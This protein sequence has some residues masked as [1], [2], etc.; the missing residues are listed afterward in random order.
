MRAILSALL[1]LGCGDPSQPGVKPG[2][3]TVSDTVND[4]PSGGGGGGGDTPVADE[5]G[6]PGT[7]E[8]L[9]RSGSRILRRMLQGDDG[10]QQFLGFIDQ[11]TGA[12]CAYQDDGTGIWRCLPTQ[13]AYFEQDYST[14]YADSRC[15]N[16]LA[17]VNRLVCNMTIPTALRGP[18]S[19]GVAPTWYAVGAEYVG[20]TYTLL[21]GVCSEDW[22]NTT[23]RYFRVGA[24]LPIT[25]FVAATEVVE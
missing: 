14:R 10:S 19:C 25:T 5:T 15:R 3:D 11:Q 7:P 9:Y 8:R 18:D 4:T 20:Q 17:T 21:D 23:V 12:P 1:L 13:V 2:D 22:E 16:A 24:E 6:G